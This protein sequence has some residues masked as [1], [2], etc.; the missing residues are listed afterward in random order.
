MGQIYVTR[1][2]RTQNI[3]NLLFIRTDCNWFV[4]SRSC[5]EANWPGSLPILLSSTHPCLGSCSLIRLNRTFPSLSLFP[6][7]DLIQCVSPPLIHIP[8]LGPITSPF[9]STQARVNWQFSSEGG[10]IP[11][12][13]TFF[14]TT[15]N[16]QIQIL[17]LLVTAS[18]LFFPSRISVCQS[19]VPHCRLNMKNLKT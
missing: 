10:F 6:G 16:A 18:S 3:K 19:L 17:N 5:S 1:F 8:H 12:A 13:V 2:F 7:W 14:A 9:S 15:V 11:W 4:Q